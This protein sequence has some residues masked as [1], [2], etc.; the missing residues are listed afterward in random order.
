MAAPERVEKCIIG[1]VELLHSDNVGTVG[2]GA[3]A[4]QDIYRELVGGV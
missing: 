4:S 2:D 3:L 1:G